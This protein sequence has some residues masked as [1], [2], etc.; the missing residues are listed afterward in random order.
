MT[1]GIITC[2]QPLAGETGAKIL[3]SGGNAFDSALAT[4][5]TQWILD[6][7]MCGMGGMGIAQIYDLSLIH[8]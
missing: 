6:P 4:A 7:F 3:E 1:N 2:P 5:F 8:I